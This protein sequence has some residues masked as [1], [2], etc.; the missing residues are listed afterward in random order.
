MLKMNLETKTKCQIGGFI[1]R[2]IFYSS[3]W[4]K[5]GLLK[6]R[7][8]RVGIEKN[9]AQNLGRTYNAWINTEKMLLK[10]LIEILGSIAS[11]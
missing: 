1:L 11:W 4:G 9:Q 8:I 10:S 5:M 7:K 2:I 6:E 3:I